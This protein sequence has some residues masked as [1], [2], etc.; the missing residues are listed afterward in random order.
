MQN[1][2]GLP[3]IHNRMQETQ[4]NGTLVKDNNTINIRFIYVW[5][6]RKWVDE[7]KSCFY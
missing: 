5:I 4:K 6:A 1:T 2:S 3:K 7:T